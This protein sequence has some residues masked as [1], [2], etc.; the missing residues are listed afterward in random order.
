M[1]KNQAK[2]CEKLIEHLT[3]KVQGQFG[4]AM[5]CILVNEAKCDTPKQK[6]VVS[7]MVSDADVVDQKANKE[8]QMKRQGQNSSP[9]WTSTERK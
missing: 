8:T 3:T 2:N 1:D 5:S 9:K 6:I 4:A 7:K